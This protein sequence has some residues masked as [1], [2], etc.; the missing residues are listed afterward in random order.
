MTIMIVSLVNFYCFFISLLRE[1][2]WI[3]DHF[4]SKKS[5]VSFITSLTTS[6]KYRPIQKTPLIGKPCTIHKMRVKHLFQ[7]ET[8][9]NHLWRTP[10]ETQDL[11]YPEHQIN[12]EF[13]L[14]I[15]S[16][17]KQLF[18]PG[19]QKLKMNLNEEKGTVAWII[20]EIIHHPDTAVALTLP[21]SRVYL[22]L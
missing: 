14:E 3:Q 2:I 18:N 20:S 12:K 16:Q 15:N 21:Q 13:K 7:Q 5:R 6:L 4:C 10:W 9:W 8:R 11:F 1:V 22:V 19:K 17:C